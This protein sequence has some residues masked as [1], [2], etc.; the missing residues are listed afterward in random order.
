MELRGFIHSPAVTCTPDTSLAEAAHEMAMRN[1]GSIIVL[2]DEGTV[3]GILTDRD[4]ALRGMGN[5]REPDTPVAEI[6][7]TDVVTLEEDASVFDAA[8]AM[9]TS[10]CRRLPVLGTDDTLKGVVALDDL[11]QLFA[12]QTDT[13]AQVV[14]REAATPERAS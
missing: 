4:I 9:A 12:H 7:T 8:A 5:R 13:L 2:D 3:D 1:V 10:A 6:M 11:M 14:A